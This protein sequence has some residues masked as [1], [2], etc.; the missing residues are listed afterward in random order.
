MLPDESDDHD[1]PLLM[2]SPRSPATDQGSP[3]G[4]AD[5]PR[6]RSRLLR[7]AL[8]VTPSRGHAV[9]TGFPDDEGNS[10]EVVR[11]LARHVPVY[12]L[13]AGTPEELS[14]LVAD[15]E[16]GDRVHIVAKNS[17]AAYAAYLSASWVFFTHGLFGSPEPPPHKTFVNV[18]HGDGPKRRKGFATVG[19]TYIVSGTR[20]WGSMRARHF[21]MPPDRVLQTGYPRVDQMHRAASPEALRALGLDPDRPLVMLM[22]TYR[23]T[24]SPA[25]RVG[26]V[27][28]WSDGN[29]LSRSEE[30]R[31]LLAHAARAAQEC[32]LTLAVK[33]NPLDADRFEGT[34]IRRFD[35]AD[36][37]PAYRVLLP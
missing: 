26:G 5:A 29:E 8:R 34:G 19:A 23:T 28:N 10:V 6:W 22:P 16:G 18:W 12:W 17:P 37:R 21:D 9:V 1:V 31:A 32:G 14:W 4:R 30:S 24:D 27:L 35:N 25:Q 7:A 15:A 13:V 33:P 11:A 2:P 20:L 36:R 3:V